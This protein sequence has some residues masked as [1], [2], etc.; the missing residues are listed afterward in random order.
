[1]RRCGGSVVNPEYG[2]RH[3]GAYSMMWGYE[4]SR[5]RSYPGYTWIGMECSCWPV[6]VRRTL[7]RYGRILRMVCRNRVQRSL[8]VRVSKTLLH[9]REP[10][11][12]PCKSHAPLANPTRP[13]L[14][15]FSSL[16]PRCCV[17]PPRTS[18]LLLLLLLLPLLPYITTGFRSQPVSSARDCAGRSHHR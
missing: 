18:A 13:L 12:H 14:V 17:E 2:S 10:L 15:G 8:I 11:A 5:P 6:Y 3:M 16:S 9:T 7:W 1:M 4:Y